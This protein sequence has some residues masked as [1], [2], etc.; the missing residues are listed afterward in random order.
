MKKVIR[1][2]KDYDSQLS[3][4]DRNDDIAFIINEQIDVVCEIE[5]T[6]LIN[7]VEDNRNHIAPDKSEFDAKTIVTAKGYSQGD[8]QQYTLYHHSDDKERQSIY[9]RKR[10]S[11]RRVGRP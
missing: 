9:L 6:S 2:N 4:E 8:W 1:I 3:W 7:I 11:L 5:N 10:Y